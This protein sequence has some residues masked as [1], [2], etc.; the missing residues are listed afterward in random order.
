[1]QRCRYLGNLILNGDMKNIL[2]K[3][4]EFEFVEYTQI[5]QSLL[6]FAHIDPLIINENETN[7][8]EWKKAKKEWRKI[9]PYISSYNP[10]GPKPE[11]VK[12][13]YKLN[14]IKENLESAIAKRDEVQN[15]SFS[16]LQLVDYILLVIKIRYDDIEQRYNTV[17]QYKQERD[18]II[19]ANDEI[20]EERNKL[21]EEFRQINPN[22]VLPGEN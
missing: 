8:L 21:I 19:K 14:K 2:C 7:K 5:F 11:Q 13:I 1:M 18:E 6:Y 12:G 16:L 15:Y 9:F 4:D 10:I 17:K 3:F 20:E 22:F